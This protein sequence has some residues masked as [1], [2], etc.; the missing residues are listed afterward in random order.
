MTTKQEIQ[1][2]NKR[3]KELSEQADKEK[4]PILLGRIQK[5]LIDLEACNIELRCMEAM[6]D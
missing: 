5:T 6:G 2:N 1:E 4:D 3:I